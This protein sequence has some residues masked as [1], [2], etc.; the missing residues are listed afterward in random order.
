MQN[1]FYIK[2]IFV[3]PNPN[4]RLLFMIDYDNIGYRGGSDTFKCELKLDKNID[5]DD[6]LETF[7]EELYSFNYDDYPVMLKREQ[8]ISNE[9]Y[10]YQLLKSSIDF[11]RVNAQI[12]PPNF[13]FINPNYM[14][15]DKINKLIGNSI[16][17][18]IFYDKKDIIMGRK[19]TN[20]NVEP[21]LYLSFNYDGL[22]SVDVIGN[23]AKNQYL[24]LKIK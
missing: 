24:I 7:F 23:R 5:K 12:G 11:L 16:D 21:G 18:V 22:F 9:K 20:P 13:I 4:D 17:N 2:S 3:G 10:F 19:N 14:K 1:L 15:I 8:N 6:I